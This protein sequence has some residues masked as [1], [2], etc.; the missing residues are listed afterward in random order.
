MTVAP[1][2]RVPGRRC[3]P[4]PTSQPKIHKLQP[5]RAA[6]LQSKKV[7]AHPEGQGFK[8]ASL[9]AGRRRCW[10]GACPSMILS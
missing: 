8:G 7:G 10:E 1:P 6:S 4:P 9:V 2:V 3:L 5:Q